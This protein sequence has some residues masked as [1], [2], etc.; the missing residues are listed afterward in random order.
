MLPWTDM[1]PDDEDFEYEITLKWTRTLY[2]YF[3]EQLGITPA[4]VDSGDAMYRTKAVTDQLCALYGLDPDGVKEMWDP[5]PEEYWPKSEAVR[6]TIGHM[7][8]CKGVDRAEKV[9]R[10]CRMCSLEWGRADFGV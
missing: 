8:A 1:M 3:R 9:S 4:I 2:D 6:A 10:G 7:L 5:V